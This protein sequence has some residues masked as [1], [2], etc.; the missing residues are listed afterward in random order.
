MQ[1]KSSHKIV[2]PA[3]DNP[4]EVSIDYVMQRM[5]RLGDDPLFASSSAAYIAV[6]CM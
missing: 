1:P 5:I 3:S 6:M 4:A 2:R